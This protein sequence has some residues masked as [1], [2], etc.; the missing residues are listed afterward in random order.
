MNKKILTL[1]L[2]LIAISTISIV[3]AQDTQKIGD[4]EF[5]IP[6]GYVY[7]EASVNIFLEAFADDETIDDA[8]VFVKDDTD[9]LAILVCSEAQ[10]SDYVSDYEIENKTIANKTGTLF[11]APDETNVVFMYE[12]G[13]KFI[14]IQALDEDTI[15]STIK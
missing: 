4:V 6:E 11:T 2:L 3:S 5:N 8:G 15:E 9:L 7:D 12:E 1:L 14:L 13:D 10:D